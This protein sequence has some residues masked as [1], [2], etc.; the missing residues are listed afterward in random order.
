M[1]A[2]TRVFAGEATKGGPATPSEQAAALS[3][4]AQKKVGDYKTLTRT[5]FFFLCVLTARSGTPS[6]LGNYVRWILEEVI[7]D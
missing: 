2:D 5:F 6:E 3:G 7:R 4:V 1:K